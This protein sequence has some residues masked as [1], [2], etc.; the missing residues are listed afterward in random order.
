MRVA[1]VAPVDAATWPALEDLFGR[2]GASN[3][4]WCMYWI[5]GAGYHKGPRAQNRR[6]LRTSVLSGPPPGLL[7]LDESGAAVGWCR[8]TLR[9][10]L[11]WLGSKPALGRVD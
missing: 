6:Q 1:T 4:C 8:L 9:A 7:A 11:R 5:L 2:S 10:E 3:G